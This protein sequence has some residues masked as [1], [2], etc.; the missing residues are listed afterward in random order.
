M[1]SG[2]IDDYGQAV[3]DYFLEFFSNTS[4]AHDN[5]NVYLHSQV[6]KDV[7][8]NSVDKSLRNLYFDRTD[9]FEEYY[10]LLPGRTEPILF[11]SISAASPGDNINYFERERKGAEQQIPIHLEGD[12]TKRWLQRNSTHF[13]QIIIPRIPGSSVFKLTNFAAM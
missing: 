3:D 13:V 1:N 8:N 11:M 6:I 10:K 4:K 7:K 5:A 12:R 2:V 9:L